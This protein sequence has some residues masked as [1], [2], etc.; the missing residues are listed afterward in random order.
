MATK[1]EVLL[2]HAVEALMRLYFAH[3][4]IFKPDG[5][6]QF[7]PCP[8]LEVARLRSFVEFK[9]RVKDE[10]IVGIHTEQ[11]RAQMTR[12]FLGFESPARMTPSPSEEEW[13]AGADCVVQLLSRFAQRYLD[14]AHLYNAAKHGLV[15]RMGPKRL[16]LLAPDQEALIEAS[17]PSIE[18]LEVQDRSGQARWYQ[19]TAWIDVEHTMTNVVLAIRMMK[20]LWSI[21]KARYLGERLTHIDLYGGDLQKALLQGSGISL[22]KASIELL[23][24]AP[25]KAS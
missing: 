18:Y 13:R 10:L 25:K 3:Q 14:N 11:R 4:P 24:Y 12:V 20:S 2:H 23:Y 19:T 6:P 21:A 15:V 8:W 22:N 16:Q 5:Q 17:G 9:Q 7:P 1:V